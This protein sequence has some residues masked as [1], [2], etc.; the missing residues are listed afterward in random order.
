[1]D[2]GCDKLCRPGRPE[3]G[4]ESNLATYLAPSW[5]HTCGQIGYISAAIAG[6]PEVRLVSNEATNLLPTSWR[7][8]ANS[9]NNAHCLGGPRSAHGIQLGSITPTKF[10]ASTLETRSGDQIVAVLNG[11]MRV[12]WLHTVCSLWGPQT[13]KEIKRGHVP[14]FCLGHPHKR[15]LST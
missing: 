6:A 11:H 8:K 12:H 14:N 5:A 13:G 1:M 9:R 4:I 10:E 2:E 15:K 7:T 3:M